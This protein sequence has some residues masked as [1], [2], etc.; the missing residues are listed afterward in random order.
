MSVS[1]RCLEGAYLKRY[2]RISRHVDKAYVSLIEQLE[3]KVPLP[4]WP[5]AYVTPFVVQ[6]KTTLPGTGQSL[7]RTFFNLTHPDVQDFNRMAVYTTIEFL[8]KFPEFTMAG[9]GHE[10]AHLIA[11]KGFVKLSLEDILAEAN[12]LLAIQKKEARKDSALRLFPPNLQNLIQIWDK[13]STRKSTEL[14]VLRDAWPVDYETFQDIV[15]GNEREAFDKFVGD[16]MRH[17]FRK[18]KK[19]W[20][21][22]EGWLRQIL[23]F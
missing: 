13:L 6:M 1:T 4:Y 12:P 5:V 8:E 11:E 19:D 16:M 17:A 23:G 3:Q 20:T 21:K 22:D 9:L 7:H 2:Q 18:K 14:T 15:F 10:F